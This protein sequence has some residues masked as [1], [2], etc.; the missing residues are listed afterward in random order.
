M[1][2]EFFTGQLHFL[3]SA[4]YQSR[5]ALDLL[6]NYILFVI[7]FAAVYRLLVKAKIPSAVLWSGAAFTSFF[8][9]IVQILIGINADNSGIDSALGALGYFT[10][11]FL[12]VFYSS[13]IFLFGASFTKVYADVYMGN[14]TITK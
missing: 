5:Y 11:L 14:N 4:A 8:F 1:I 3:L 2:L 12:W 13:L 10:I 9:T 6:F 7:L